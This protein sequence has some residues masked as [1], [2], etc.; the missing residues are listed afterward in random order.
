VT[1]EIFM[2]WE[3][4][5][6][7]N[8]DHLDEL[9]QKGWELVTVI[10]QQSQLK[11]YFNKPVGNLKERITDEQRHEVYSQLESGDKNEVKGDL[12]P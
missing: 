10:Q 7:E 6:T 2:K 5:I 12:T 4:L 9:G 8:D 11:F 3:Y 1:G